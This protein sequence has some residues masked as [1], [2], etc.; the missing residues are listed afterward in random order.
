MTIAATLE[1][2]AGLVRGADPALIVGPPA[3]GMNAA[4][5]WPWRFAEAPVA[6]NH[7][8]H[9]GEPPQ[10]RAAA[11]DLHMLVLPTS[12]GA[13]GVLDR[14]LSLVAANPMLRTADGPV[15]LTIGSGLASADLAALFVSA[16]LPVSV[17]IELVAR[18]TPA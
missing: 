11:F 13:I 16:R 4:C 17:C 18:T 1:A 2:V 7:P 10:R 8:S 14:T 5:L 6:T 15:R 9:I 3:A 12:T